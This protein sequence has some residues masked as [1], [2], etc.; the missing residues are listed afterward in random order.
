MLRSQKRQMLSKLLEEMLGQHPGSSWAVGN[1]KMNAQK[2]SVNKSK[3][4][5]AVDMVSKSSERTSII[6]QQPSKRQIETNA[7]KQ[8]A[9]LQINASK[10]LSQSS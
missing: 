4:L 3:C 1:W 8:L 2:Q 9:K 7:Q 6:D 10:Q 5:E